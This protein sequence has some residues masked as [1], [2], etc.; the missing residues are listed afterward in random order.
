MRRSLGLRSGAKLLGQVVVGVIFAVLAIRFPD[1]NDLT[2]ASEH[3]SFNADWC[4]QP[5][6]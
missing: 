2:P 6:S 1:G 4:W 5:T 3:L